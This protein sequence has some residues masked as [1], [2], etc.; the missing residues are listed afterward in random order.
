MTDKDLIENEYYG[1][2]AN[3]KNTFKTRKRDYSK[4]TVTTYETANPKIPD[5]V[6]L[7]KVKSSEDYEDNYDRY[8]KN[9][10]LYA[11]VNMRS[12]FSV[13]VGFDIYAND[14]KIEQYLKRKLRNVGLFYWDNTVSS[15]M[16]N[17]AKR[18]DIFGN[19]YWEK[20]FDDDGNIV[21]VKEINP[22]LI[23]PLINKKTGDLVGY[24]YEMEYKG[25]T[26]TIASIVKF[27]K[28][29][30]VIHFSENDIED[31]PLGA[32]AIIPLLYE[33]DAMIDVSAISLKILKKYIK[34][35][36]HYKYQIMSGESGA[37]IKDRI[38]TLG[39]YLI[40]Q[41]QDSD[42]ISTDRWSVEVIKSQFMMDQ[43][44]LY[45][46]RLDSKVIHACE[47]PEAFFKPKGITDLQI[48]HQIQKFKRAMKARQSSFGHKILEELLLPI[49]ERE[50][51][52]N[53][54]TI[55]DENLPW[56]SWNEIVDK[57]FVDHA[58][59]ATELY[60]NEIIT[61]D[62]ARDMVGYGT[63]E[64]TIEEDPEDTT[65]EPEVVEKDTENVE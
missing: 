27:L 29:K 48:A 25:S 59:I 64:E 24:Q 28:I 57:D 63:M 31:S 4:N 60:T 43:I 56:I 52:I 2:F 62:E 6:N 14:E 26:G 42:F 53:K 65:K 54:D 49:I 35:M 18:V 7:L 50:F 10:L 58:K 47:I 23:F 30:E 45:L 21:K 33:I 8:S 41:K 38:D 44:N 9:A 5:S 16:R 1:C 17:L 12:T 37:K 19:E 11:C 39:D 3:P 15:I 61:I 40:E 51:G 36:L 32:S 46:D 34:P 55:D 13:G 22:K 20:I